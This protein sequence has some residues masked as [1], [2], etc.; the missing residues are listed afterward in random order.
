MRVR[1]RCLLAIRAGV[2]AAVVCVSPLLA[3]ADEPSAPPAIGTQA[4][5]LAAGPFFPIR[6]LPGQSSKLFGG[7]AIPS[8]AMTLTDPVGSS[9]YRGQIALGAELLGFRTSEPKTA[10]GV[11]VTPKLEYRLTG[12][13]RLRPYIE[14]GGGPLWT[15]LGGRVP[16]Q[17]GQFNFVVWGGAGCAW[18][19]T[20]QWALNAGYR[21]VHI[22]NAGTRTPNSGLNFGLPLVGISYSFS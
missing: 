18:L 16:E 20:P 1:S 4:V 21:F 2:L 3:R 9:W 5:G 15:D 17:P 13:G 22:S 19:L 12:F 10:S 6:L 8:W 7:A 11:G 14:G